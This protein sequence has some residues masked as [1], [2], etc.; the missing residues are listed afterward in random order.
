M[1]M[2]AIG[3]NTTAG[4]PNQEAMM[5]AVAKTRLSAN[6]NEG[7]GYFIMGFTFDYL[8]FGLI[9][10]QA[11]VWAPNISQERKFVIVVAVRTSIMRF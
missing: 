4:G 11:I 1:D 5:E 7:L 6:G 2:S 8:F 3:M 9:L 10:H